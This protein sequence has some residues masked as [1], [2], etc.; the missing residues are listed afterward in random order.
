[1]I[2][3]IATDETTGR[4]M[5]GMIITEDN[6]ENLKKDMPI[7]FHVEQMAGIGNIIECHEVIIIYFKTIEEAMEY[8][9]N[10]GMLN[11]AT[12]IKDTTKH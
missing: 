11:T 1:M 6:I 8:F 3:F 10:T 4:R 9:K 2:K 7:H 5:L 12:I